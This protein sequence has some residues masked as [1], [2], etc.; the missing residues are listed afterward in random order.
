MLNLLGNAHQHGRDDGL[1]R[2]RVER[3]PGEA[4]LA[5]DDD[6]PGIPAAEQSRIFER[7]YRS[8]QDAARSSPG[9]G[10]GLPIA[11]AIVNLHGGRI[12]VE[13]APG[14]GATF[15]VALPTTRGS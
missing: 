14:A 5:V 4:P 3:H 11:R 7:F 1:I 15:Y 6:G 8:G 2:V 9:S 13:S 12:W 10:L